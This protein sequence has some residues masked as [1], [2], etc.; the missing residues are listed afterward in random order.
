MGLDVSVNKL[1]HE[2]A[3]VIV[4]RNVKKYKVIPTGHFGHAAIMLRG[5][6]LGLPADKYPYISWWPG[7][8]AGKGDALSLQSGLHETDYH[9]DMSDEMADRSR[10]ALE[11][12]RYAPRPG[13]LDSK[14]GWGSASD[15][16][17]SLPGIGGPGNTAHRFGLCL[18]RMRDWFTNYRTSG[19]GYQLASTTKSCAGV[20]MVALKEGGGGGFLK[21]PNMLIM[22]EPKAVEGYARGLQREIID[23]N[24]RVRLFEN[25]APNALLKRQRLM[26]GVTGFVTPSKLW[27][28]SEWKKL[29]SVKGAI[30]SSLVRDI[31]SLLAKYHKLEW[32]AEFGDKYALLIQ[33][34][35]KV[36][37]HREKKPDSKRAFP[38]TRLGMQILKVVEVLRTNQSP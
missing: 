23:L 10:D 11:E 30:R 7:D 35:D 15:A 27:S 9:Q 16:Q 2:E 17:V 25:E 5:D 28:V 18:P 19:G 33:L 21:P 38:M 31:D 13:Q 14:Q 20:A 4:W 8:G 29:S 34:M 6:S 36:M 24:R 3:T 12:G 22:A 32:D 26:F 1:F 37:K